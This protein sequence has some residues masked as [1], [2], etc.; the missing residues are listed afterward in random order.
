MPPPAS[1]CRAPSRRKQT[2][3]MPRLRRRCGDLAS[4]RNALARRQRGCEFDLG[5][6]QVEGL[7][8]M[9]FDELQLRERGG[10]G[11]DVVAVLYFI[12]PVVRMRSS[13]RRSD[14]SPSRCNAAAT[15]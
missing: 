13:G 11:F 4:D 9:G 1:R 8:R 15:L 5:D 3:A 14:A 7:L 6:Q 12:E 10:E 2:R